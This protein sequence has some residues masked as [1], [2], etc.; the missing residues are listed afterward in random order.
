MAHEWCERRRKKSQ[1][2]VI[3]FK[4]LDGIDVFSS[5]KGQNFDNDSDD[6]KKVIKFFRSGKKSEIVG[7]P[8]KAKKLRSLD[9]IFGPIAGDGVRPKLPSWKPKAFN[10][11]MRYQL[12]LRTPAM[13]D[14]FYNDG[15][16]VEKAI[17]FCDTN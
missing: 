3:V 9:Y 17:F 13:A 12:C 15:K 6:W 7:G 16:N 14:D 8:S 4:I 1:T 10:N 11:P 5:R 2:A